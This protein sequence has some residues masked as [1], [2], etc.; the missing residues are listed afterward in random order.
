MLVNL[1][2]Y[3]II[4]NQESG[5]GRFDVMILHKTNKDKLAIIMELKS[6]R[7]LKNETKDEALKSAIEQIED[8][9]YEITTK[10]RGYKNIL[11][12]AVVFDGKRVWTKNSEKKELKKC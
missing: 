5:Y 6:L 11:K 9:K 12:I 8:K 1:N 4:S 10:K 3:E 2:D 7:K